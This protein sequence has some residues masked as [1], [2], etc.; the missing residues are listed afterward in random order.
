MSESKELK[1]DEVLGLGDKK[2]LWERAVWANSKDRCANC[3]GSDRLQIHMAVPLEA[4]GQYVVSNG[5]L[6]CRVC[7]LAALAAANT[8][9]AFSRP[10]N[11]WVSRELYTNLTSGIKR[12]KGFNSMGALVRHLMR[13]YVQNE[14]RFEDLTS[15]QDVGTDVKIN[16]WVDPTEYES[17]KTLV[18][19][20]GSTVTDTIK[21]L[22]RMYV[23][24]AEPLLPRKE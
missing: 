2:V 9:K 7:E 13:M 11:F 10:L 18:Q 24:D 12:H 1:V 19:S 8:Q 14:G 6:L 3:G 5:F 16:V 21:S 22:I 23:L 20:M 17:F 4:G 15:Y